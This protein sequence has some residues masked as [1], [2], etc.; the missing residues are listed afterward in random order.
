MAELAMVFRYGVETRRALE[1]VKA[2]DGVS[3]HEQVRRA[4]EAWLAGQDVPATTRE[5]RLEARAARV[6]RLVED[7]GAGGEENSAGVLLKAE[8]DT[9]VT[10][11]R[12]RLANRGGD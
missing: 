5:A 4:V 6:A 10:Q 12:Q 2:R 7:Q 11:L 3:F 9:D 1:A 8:A